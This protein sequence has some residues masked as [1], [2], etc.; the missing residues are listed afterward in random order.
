MEYTI[1]ITKLLQKLAMSLS[2]TFS[3]TRLISIESQTKKIVVVVVV[4]IGIVVVVVHV[5]VIPVV[6][7]RN[8]PLKFG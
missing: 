5:V 8:T 6:D 2:H 7:P 4:V 3:K 1:L